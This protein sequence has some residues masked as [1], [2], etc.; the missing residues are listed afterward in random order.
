MVTDFGDAD[1]LYPIKL[2]DGQS[3]HQNLSVLNL[4]CLYMS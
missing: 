3:F 4:P 2:S 1:G